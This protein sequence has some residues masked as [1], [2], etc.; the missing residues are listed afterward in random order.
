MAKLF[1]LTAFFAIYFQGCLVDA[2][3]F[4]VDATKE[5]CFYELL[6]TGEPVGLMFQV[7]QG[8]FLDIDVEIKSPDGRVVYTAQRQTEGKYNFGATTAGLYSFCFSNKMSTLT[9]KVVSFMLN[10]LKESDKERKDDNVATQEHITPLET[11][12]LQLSAELSAVQSEQSYMK[13]RERAHRNTNESTNSRVV[14]WSIFEVVMLLAMSAWQIYYLRRFFE[15][16][17]IV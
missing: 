9:P 8:G 14:W 6:N 16:K 5:E 13:M 12:I 15:V 7:V 3:T 1:L 17:R 10:L 2:F 4:Q 11:A